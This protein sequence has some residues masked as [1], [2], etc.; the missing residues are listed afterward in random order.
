MNWHS[1][2]GSQPKDKVKRP[3]KGSGCLIYSK[4][5]SS[6]AGICLK[7]D[8]AYTV[9]KGWMYHQCPQ[10]FLLYK[11]PF[12]AQFMR[13]KVQDSDELI[14][15]TLLVFSIF[16]HIGSISAVRLIIY[17][18]NS[19]TFDSITLSLSLKARWRKGFSVWKKLS[20]TMDLYGLIWKS[21][22]YCFTYFQRSCNTSFI[23]NNLWIQT[24]LNWLFAQ[25]SFSASLLQFS[26]V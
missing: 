24:V 4:L 15:S 2:L 1:Q 6:E 22:L 17:T 23:I 8:T 7:E 14:W 25:L 5:L 21:A 12:K 13:V 11:I 16:P 18:V 19:M 9:L 10:A 26:S 3:L 20:E